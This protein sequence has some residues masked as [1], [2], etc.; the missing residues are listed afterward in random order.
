MNC[1]TPGSL[2]FA[3]SQSLPKFTESVIPSNHL[4]FS[5]PLLMPSIFPRSGSFP[6]SQL[7][8]SEGQ[9]VGVSASASGLPINYSGLISFRIDW[10][11]LLPVQGTFKHLLQHHNSK[12]SI[13][14]PPAFFM[15]QLSYPYMITRKAITLT[16]WTFA[17][18]VMSLLF[19][20]LPWLL[21]AFLPRSKHL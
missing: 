21:V 12:A 9:S 19:I 16:I 20:M 15:L 1:T 14:Q 3:I 6:V 2:S 8:T 13:L 18:K 7:F 4:I 10:F 17:S 5:H 11:D